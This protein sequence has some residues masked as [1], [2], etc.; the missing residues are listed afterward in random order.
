MA[1]LTAREDERDALRAEI[2]KLTEPAVQHV[3]THAELETIYR[4][5]VERLESLLT[6]S[7]QMVATN[8]LLKDLLGEIR[9]MGDPEAADG[10]SITLCSAA[11][12]LL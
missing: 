7:D 6:G 4:A 2:A 12:Q 1:R 9:V 5:Q 3:P 10:V 11:A 8:A